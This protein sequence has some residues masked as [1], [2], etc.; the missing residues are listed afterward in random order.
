M[1]QAHFSK[2]VT[3]LADSALQK[4]YV[5]IQHIIDMNMQIASAAEEQSLVTEEINNNTV[6]T[7][8]LLTQVSDGAAESNIAMKVQI[9]NV[10]EQSEILSKFVV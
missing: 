9:E 5:A 8:D 10:R 7:K 1:L 2:F 4:I 3:Q 6:K